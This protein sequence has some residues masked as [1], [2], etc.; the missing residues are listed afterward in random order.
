[1]IETI[2]A[3]TGV[4][5]LLG[6]L[7]I[8]AY[9]YL[10]HQATIGK[11]RSIQEIV[12][13]EGLFNANQIKDILVEFKDDEARLK[14]LTTLANLDQEKAKALLAKINKNI[15]INELNSKT[16]QTKVKLSA[17]T[18]AFFI[19]VSV[20]GLVYINIAPLNPPDGHSGNN[21]SETKPPAPASQPVATSTAGSQTT[22]PID[23]DDTN[24]TTSQVATAGSGGVAANIK[25]DNNSVKV[26][27]HYK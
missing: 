12:Q 4:T 17:L 22:H 23:S 13:G 6:L 26:N 19:L 8:L 27:N 14:A 11:D 15:N 7:A 1:M 9:F 16:I 5:G 21:S 25:G 24:N 18:A 3:L 10:L 2:K 20:I